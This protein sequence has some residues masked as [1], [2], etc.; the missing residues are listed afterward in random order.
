MATMKTGVD[1]FVEL[2]EELYEIHPTGG[3]LHVVLDD[4]NI[5]GVIQPW[6]DGYTPE[7]L[8]ALYYKGWPIADLPPE[9]PAV[10]EGLGVSTR[11]LCEEIAGLMNGWTVQQRQE[12]I[13]RWRS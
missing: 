1:R 2:V 9:A 12:A 6:Y 8:D 7:E 3:P 10:V 4:G 13:D 11:R 5:D